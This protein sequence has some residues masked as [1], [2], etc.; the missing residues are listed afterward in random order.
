MEN[1]GKVKIAVQ[2]LTKEDVIIAIPESNT[3]KEVHQKLVEMLRHKIEDVIHYW[4]YLG[5]IGE[6]SDLIIL[7]ENQYVG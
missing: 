4:L 3:I 6:T 2:L 5:N 1:N 7:E